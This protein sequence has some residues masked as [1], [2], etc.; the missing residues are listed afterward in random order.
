[1]NHSK[2]IPDGWAWKIYV[3][4]DL[5][6]NIHWFIQLEFPEGTGF[7]WH[8]IQ[9]I[10]PWHPV[11]DFSISVLSFSQYQLHHQTPLNVPCLCPQPYSHTTNQG[12]PFLE[13]NWLWQFQTSWFL[14][15]TI[16]ILSF[17]WFCLIHEK[18]KEAFF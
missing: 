3:I 4:A 16:R 6:R 13:V 12:S 1:M 15:H 11:A 18:G 9:W 17:F 10:K 8:L 7:R 5:T 14:C 2:Q